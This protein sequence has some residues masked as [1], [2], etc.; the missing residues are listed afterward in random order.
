MTLVV[1]LK[2]PVAL[3]ENVPVGEDE[4]N[5]ATTGASGRAGTPA[6]CACRVIA[7]DTAPA[8]TDGGV[9]TNASVVGDHARNARQLSVSL[10]PSR[11]PAHQRLRP[12]GPQARTPGS[13][14]VSFAESRMAVASRSRTAPVTV[15]HW[16]AGS[17]DELRG[18]HANPQWSLGRPDRTL[19]LRR[20]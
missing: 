3:V 10:A 16:S 6:T 13:A 12:L 20:A 11:S 18:D 15:A 17:D 8:T 4:A 7:P 5:V 9:E 19:W 1:G 14:G 2:G